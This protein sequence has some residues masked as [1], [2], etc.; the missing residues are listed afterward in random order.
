M[1]FEAEGGFTGLL[2]GTNE[3]PLVIDGLWGLAFGNGGR[4]GLPDTLYFTAGPDGESHGLFGSL[5][6]VPEPK[7]GKGHGDGQD[8]HH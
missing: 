8:K 4:A 1:S 7:H 6:V 5:S 3:K 2:E